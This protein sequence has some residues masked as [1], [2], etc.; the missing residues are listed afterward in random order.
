MNTDLQTTTVSPSSPAYQAMNTVKRE[1]LLPLCAG[2]TLHDRSIFSLAILRHC[3]A[4]VIDFTAAELETCSF[5]FSYYIAGS[6]NT[7]CATSDFYMNKRMRNL[8]SLQSYNCI[9]VENVVLGKATTSTIINYPSPP[10]S[11]AT[12]L[13][14]HDEERTRRKGEQCEFDDYLESFHYARSSRAAPPLCAK[15]A[16]HTGAETIGAPLS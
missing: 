7:R 15:C 14:Y 6:P 12:K 1:S 4:F 16:A 11:K 9:F 13:P 3:D 2:S 10:P 8:P 5:A